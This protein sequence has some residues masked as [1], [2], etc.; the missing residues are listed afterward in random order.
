MVVTLASYA[1]VSFGHHSVGIRFL[2]YEIDDLG[3][4]VADD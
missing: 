2:I 3:N 4:C 1:A